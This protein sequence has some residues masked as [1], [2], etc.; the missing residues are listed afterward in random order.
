MLASIL[1]IPFFFLFKIANY[2]DVS[3]IQTLVNFKRWEEIMTRGCLKK[4]MITLK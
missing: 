1:K 3:N 4:E 2:F